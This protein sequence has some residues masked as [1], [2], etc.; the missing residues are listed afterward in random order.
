MYIYDGDATWHVAQHITL[1]VSSRY[2]DISLQ[3]SEAVLAIGYKDNYGKGR[4]DLYERH[5]E[6]FRI[7]QTLQPSE[8]VDFFGV[9]VALYGSYLAVSSKKHTSTII[10]TYRLHNTTGQWNNDGKLT[11]PGNNDYGYL[12]LGH[13][14][15]AVTVAN[16]ETL[17]DVCALVKIFSESL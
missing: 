7:S 6:L 11:I 10:F 2:D 3:I 1:K 5:G 15:L 14:I 13:G 4:V 12:S 8:P 9:S 16:S 17:S